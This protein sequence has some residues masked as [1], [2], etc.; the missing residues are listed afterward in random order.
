MRANDFAAFDIMRGITYDEYVFGPEFMAGF[1]SCTLQ[2]DRTQFIA[3]FVVAGEGPKSEIVPD[4][5]MIELYFRS[6]SQI[7]GK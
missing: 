1:L 6:S 7:P 3:Y 2:G 4:I 5:E